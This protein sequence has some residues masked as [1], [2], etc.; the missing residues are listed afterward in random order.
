MTRSLVKRV[1]RLEALDAAPKRIDAPFVMLLEGEQE[2]TLAPG[3]H[4][5]EDWFRDCGPIVWARERVTSETDDR[6]RRCPPGGYLLDVLEVFHE[7]CPWREKTGVC[8]M[9]QG[10]PVGSAEC[11]QKAGVQT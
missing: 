3:E 10:T 11:T 6:G 1:Q 5:V 4:V 7:A 9:C 2:R 8:Q